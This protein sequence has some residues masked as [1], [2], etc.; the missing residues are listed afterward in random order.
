MFGYSGI[1]G[2]LWG[3]WVF[4]YLGIWVFGHLG[5]WVVGYLGIFGFVAGSFCGRFA[6]NGPF[7]SPKAKGASA[8]WVLGAF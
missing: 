4:G 5:I 6:V 2:F 1:W 7:A 3:M 8:F